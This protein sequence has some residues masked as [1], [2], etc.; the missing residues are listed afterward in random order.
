MTICNIFL[1]NLY[2]LIISLKTFKFVSLSS[3]FSLSLSQAVARAFP[4]EM[5][6]SP[7]NQPRFVLKR[8]VI[9]H[10]KCLGSLLSLT[11]M[12]ESVNSSTRFIVLC[13]LLVD[14]VIELRWYSR[15]YTLIFFQRFAWIM[16]LFFLVVV[17]RLGWLMKAMACY[18]GCLL[19]VLVVHRWRTL[20]PTAVRVDYSQML[21]ATGCYY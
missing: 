10:T 5:P 18:V 4:L 8:V 7:S 17:L 1:F 2:Q 13:I 12:V 11:F 15:G 19:A 21:V 9:K 6:W 20:S 3:F 16:L 14:G